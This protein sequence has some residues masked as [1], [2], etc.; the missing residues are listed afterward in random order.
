M[1]SIWE[2]MVLEENRR[3][4]ESLGMR[5][6]DVEEQLMFLE[7]L[8]H[9]TID[10]PNS[11]TLL[12]NRP[13]VES[14]ETN[15]NGESST[16]DAATEEQLEDDDSTTRLSTSS[17]SVLQSPQ[18]IVV[19]DG[20]GPWI[21]L[22]QVLVDYIL[23]FLGDIDMIGYLAI[24]SK[25]TFV[26]SEKVFQFLCE[27]TYPRQTG[28]QVCR[29]ERWKTW[30]NMIINRPR[31]RLNGFYSLRTMFTKSYC[32][33]AFWEEKKLESIEVGKQYHI[34][35]TIGIYV[36]SYFEQLSIR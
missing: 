18:Y 23:M 22:P 6:S 1:A 36:D 2:Q 4:A 32:N 30:K 29:V 25:S 19:P 35:F 28:R 14:K 9:S 20:S 7:T 13:I 27:L 31:L 33:D 10:H 11:E 26:P 15:E 24:A 8:Q 5:I 21:L 3:L 17:P 34:M 12:V 16:V